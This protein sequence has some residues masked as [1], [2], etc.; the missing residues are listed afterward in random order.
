MSNDF[1]DTKATDVARAYE[2]MS[3]SGK[4]VE[5]LCNIVCRFVGLSFE[6]TKAL[7]ELFDEIGVCE[8]EDLEIAAYVR[9]KSRAEAREALGNWWK[10]CR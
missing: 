5:E 10:P 4:D 6:Q 8:E 9:K 1:D 7:S 3:V 2:L